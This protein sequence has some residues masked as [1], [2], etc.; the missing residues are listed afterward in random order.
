MICP[1]EAGPYVAVVAGPYDRIDVVPG[2]SRAY[3]FAIDRR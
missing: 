3:F 1:A 2:S